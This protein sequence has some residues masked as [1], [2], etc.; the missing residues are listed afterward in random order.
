MPSLCSRLARSARRRRRQIHRGLRH[1]SRPASRAPDR[2]RKRT[3]WPLQWRDACAGIGRSRRNIGARRCAVKVAP[4]QPE[5]PAWRPGLDLQQWGPTL[6]GGLDSKPPGS[7]LVMLLRVCA[8]GALGVMTVAATP[9]QAP[10]PRGSPVLQRESQVF[11]SRL[12]A[13]SADGRALR[14]A[15][16]GPLTR[17]LGRLRPVAAARWSFVVRAW[18]LGSR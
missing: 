3:L 18:A 2:V 10:L 7:D 17:G 12:S 13:L 6:S 16:L 1:A 14:A 15:L 11:Y 4:A 8:C 9:P 5:P